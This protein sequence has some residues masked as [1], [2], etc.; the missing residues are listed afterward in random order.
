MR[1]LVVAVVAV[2]LV[3]LSVQAVLAQEV[4]PV[5]ITAAFW[6][7]AV[8]TEGGDATI[9]FVVNPAPAAD[10]DVGVTITKDGDFGA[11]PIGRRTVTVPAGETQ[12][13]FAVSTVDD[14][15][16]APGSLTFTVNPGS[17]YTVGTNAVDQLTVVVDDNEPHYVCTLP[18]STPPS[19]G[20]ASIVCLDIEL[21]YDEAEP[22]V[23][24]AYELFYAGTTT[25][26]PDLVRRSG[27]LYAQRVIYANAVGP[28]GRD[29][30][31]ARWDYAHEVCGDEGFDC[32]WLRMLSSYGG[33]KYNIATDLVMR[34]AEGFRCS[35]NFAARRHSSLTTVRTPV[36]VEPPP[37][38]PLNERVAPQAE[39][40]QLYRARVNVNSNDRD[41]A[42]FAA[43]VEAVCGGVASAKG[44]PRNDDPQ[45]HYGGAGATCEYFDHRY[46]DGEVDEHGEVTLP[47]AYIGTTLVVTCDPDY[48]CS[49]N[50]TFVAA[51]PANDGPDGAP[52]TDDDVAEVPAY[53]T[54]TFTQTY[55][56]PAETT[57]RPV[58]ARARRATVGS[59]SI[60]QGTQVHRV[61]T[62]GDGEINFD[63]NTVTGA[64]TYKTVTGYW[65]DADRDGVKDSNEIHSYLVN[66]QP[67]EWR[68]STNVDY[69]YEYTSTLLLRN[70]GIT[71]VRSIT[72]PDI[73]KPE[74]PDCL[75]QWHATAPSDPDA[76]AK[77]SNTYTDFC[78]D[79]ELDA[80]DR[81]LDQWSA[82]HDATFGVAGINVYDDDGN[83]VDGSI[84]TDEPDDRE[85][86][87]PQTGTYNQG[88]EQLEQRGE[89]YYDCIPEEVWIQLVHGPRC[90][91]VYPNPQPVTN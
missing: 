80:H 82:D 49:L 89:P 22:N 27:D 61:D 52:D 50:V 28:D 53:Y 42:R 77:W 19:E 54:A 2:L 63:T 36:V 21:R 11:S 74:Q 9:R 24:E 7:N 67:N 48:R 59:V 29:P 26:V 81:A 56:E 35:V 15:V 76:L 57:P 62:D 43:V 71:S 84:Y 51:M 20:P 86:Q 47:G 18:N 33:E 83:K 30:G 85:P 60:S 25:P 3:P 69:N 37:R 79:A 23:A 46:N 73:P 12:A 91:L 58:N 16:Y 14:E 55:I 17:G 75:K 39:G 34:C 5:E 45:H 32:T 64:I 6:A 87:P 10:L 66:G 40:R 13:T 1:R 70:D 65:V 31:L 41:R 88:V 78:T 8:I 90:A 4:E 44:E 38:R 68:H 72:R